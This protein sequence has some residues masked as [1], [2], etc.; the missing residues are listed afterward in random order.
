MSNSDQQSNEESRMNISKKS[1]FYIALCAFIAGTFFGMWAYPKWINQINRRI[2]TLDLE[3]ETTASYQSTNEL[4]KLRNA[5]NEEIEIRRKSKLDFI[6]NQQ[7]MVNGWGSGQPEYEPTDPVVP[8]NATTDKTA[9]QPE[10]ESADLVV[11]D[12]ATTDKT[13]TKRHWWEK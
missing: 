4:V 3:N 9:S 5:L 8:D 12:N 1:L 13:A 7:D 10:Y 6:A 11:P 2:E